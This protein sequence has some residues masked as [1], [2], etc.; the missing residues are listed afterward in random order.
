MALPLIVRAVV[1]A[2]FGAT[3]V[4]HFIRCLDL[5]R[6]LARSPPRAR[7]GGVA[8]VNDLVHLLMSVEMVAMAWRGPARGWWSLQ[9]TVFAVATGWFL[10]QG[11]AP[12]P[13]GSVMTGAADASDSQR[14]AAPDRRSCRSVAAR[15]ASIQYA[16]VTAIMTWMIAV[17][18]AGGART[19]VG[20][21]VRM[22]GMAMSSA[23]GAG[24]LDG[25]LSAL[26]GGYL[27]LSASLWLV[28]AHRGRPQVRG[29]AP[30]IGR[31]RAAGLVSGEP[32]AG[33][34]SYAV[35]AAGMG[36]V[37]LTG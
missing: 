16:I 7:A 11:V 13:V 22:P 2:V 20:A 30:R 19:A 18:P 12:L 26:L 29:S 36:A 6:C 33:A 3:A 34:I 32:A 15:G 1:T 10:V 25:Y 9:L 23:S 8:R 35:M 37:L 31:T 17:M 24:D 27:V 21:G 14:R 5:M 28:T 4:L